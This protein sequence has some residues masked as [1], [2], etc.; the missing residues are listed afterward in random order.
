MYKV[1]AN[2]NFTSFRDFSSKKAS[3]LLLVNWTDTKLGVVDSFTWCLAKLQK[4]V[5]KPL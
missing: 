2:K 1:Y 5:I 4:Q 3:H